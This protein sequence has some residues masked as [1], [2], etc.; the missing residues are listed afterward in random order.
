MN[1]ILKQLI[2]SKMKGVPDEQVNMIIAAFEK[3]PEFFKTLAE[4]IKA[5]TDGGMSEQDAAMKVMQEHG[6]EIKKMLS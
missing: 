4:R 1:F 3:N 6:D 2:K 5:K